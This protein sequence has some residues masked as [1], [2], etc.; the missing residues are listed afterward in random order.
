MNRNP[1]ITSEEMDNLNLT[2]RGIR[3][4]LLEMRI[5]FTSSWV[6]EYHYLF[7][8]LENTNLNHFNIIIDWGTPR[9]YRILDD[10]FTAC[11]DRIHLI[12]DDSKKLLGYLYGIYLR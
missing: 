11:Q 6:P 12:S 2:D 4:F 9:G 3:R 7:H 1:F 10:T 5:F 8:N